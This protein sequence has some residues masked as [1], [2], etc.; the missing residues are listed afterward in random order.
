MKHFKF[1]FVF[2]TLTKVG[3]IAQTAMSEKINGVNFV[4]PKLKC[5]L[6]GIDSIK[7]IN[8]NWIAICPF[9]FLHKSSS[10]I[11]FNTSVN[12]WGD[13]KVGLIEEVKRARQKKF[14]VFIKP[15]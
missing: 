6:S 5:K 4:S 10:K 3:I 7:T 9:A 14:K 13:T 2:A 12:W 1:I 8:A 11:E 15:H